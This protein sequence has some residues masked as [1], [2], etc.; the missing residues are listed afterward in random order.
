VSVLLERF[1]GLLGLSAV[2]V[3]ALVVGCRRLGSPLAFNAVIGSAVLLVGVAGLIW[4]LPTAPVAGR[5]VDRVVPQ[6]I[7]RRLREF[8]GALVGSK[9]YPGA[10]LGAV[11]VSAALH[12][13]FAAYYALTAR[14][15][16]IPVDFAYFVLFLPPVT[17][18]AMVPVSIGGL[19]LREASMV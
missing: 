1:T 14:V 15:M 7:A 8:G 10:L 3:V 4:L 6:A 17:L 13:L 11:A 2:S 19:G 12:L 5:V 16:G 18:L 9:A